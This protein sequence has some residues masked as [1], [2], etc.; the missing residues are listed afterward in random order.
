[1]GKRKDLAPRCTVVVA[2]EGFYFLVA[3]SPESSPQVLSYSN[4][5]NAKPFQGSV[6]IKREEDGVL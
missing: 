1:M 2:K 6:R 4:R 3:E 5:L